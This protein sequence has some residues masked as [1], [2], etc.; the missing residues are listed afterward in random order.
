[1]YYIYLHT[2]S[3]YSLK[4]KKKIEKIESLN[5][6]AW[7]KPFT[8]KY[9]TDAICSLSHTHSRA[10]E[11]IMFHWYS[12]GV[13]YK[14]SETRVSLRLRSEKKNLFL[15]TT[16]VVYIHVYFILVGYTSARFKSFA[17]SGFSG[18]RDSLSLQ[19]QCA[20]IL[21]YTMPTFAD[22]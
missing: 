19:L 20:S 7:R 4:K 10:T 11:S 2:V 16:T 12:L 3:I 22:E 8:Y 18:V 6:I 15:E 5:L 9:D 1:L 21:Y 17:G 14:E 13:S